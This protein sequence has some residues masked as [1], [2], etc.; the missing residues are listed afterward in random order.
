MNLIPPQLPLPQ[1]DAGGMPQGIPQNIPSGIPPQIAQMLAQAQANQQFQQPQDTPDQFLQQM[2]QQ[3]QRAPVGLETPRLQIDQSGQIVNKQPAKGFGQHIR[4]ALSNFLYSL[5]QGGISHIGEQGQRRDLQMAAI[6]TQEAAAK[7]AQELGMATGRMY[8]GLGAMNRASFYGQNVAN[9]AKRADAAMILAQARDFQVHHPALANP[10]NGMLTQAFAAEGAGDYQTYNHLLGLVNQASLA[11]NVSD[12]NQYTSNYLSANGLEDTPANRMTAHQA[13]TNETKTQPGVA[14]MNV[15]AG[16]RGM[17]VT[18]SE[19]GTTA[20]MSWRDYNVLSKKFP[21]RYTSPQFDAEVQAGVSGARVA[22]KEIPTQ[23]QSF[24]AFL[25]HADD[26]ASAAK[27]TNLGQVPWANKPL[28]ELRNMAAGD[29]QITKYLAKIEPVRKEF[30][31][32][33]LNNRALY[34]EDRAQGEKI[35]S[36]ASTPQQ[37]NAAIE[38]LTHTAYIRLKALNQRAAETGAAPVI[39]DK[40]TKSILDKFGNDTSDFDL[41]RRGNLKWGIQSNQAGRIIVQDKSGKKFSLPAS[42]LPE[43]IKQGYKVV[44]R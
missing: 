8:G 27:A 20:P 12:I 9:N 7:R 33:L 35:I 21:G 40:T 32:F 37:M 19:T 29:P 4:N 24:R 41:G 36:E 38:T 42:Q 5:G 1:S 18:D 14:R 22:G 44:N 39:L 25:G 31:S 28:V 16:I 15:L 17:A 23:V 34:S 43:A 13:F 11:K 30:E 3:I 6:G 10:I 2:Q 26:L